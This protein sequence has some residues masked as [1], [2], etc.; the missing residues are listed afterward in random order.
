MRPSGIPGD[1]A[2]TTSAA[3]RQ[4]RQPSLILAAV[5]HRQPALIDSRLSAALFPQ[6]HHHGHERLSNV[7]TLEH[8][9]L[10]PETV[11]KLRS[12][13]VESVEDLLALAAQPNEREALLE[14]MKWTEAGLQA[15]VEAA[16]RIRKAN[17]G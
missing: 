5:S 2:S 15:L 10:K 13:Y 12:Q 16:M 3:V 14:D 17:V 8:L 4:Y 7:T 6:P 1:L 9:E 11:R